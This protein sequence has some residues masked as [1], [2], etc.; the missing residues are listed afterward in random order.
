MEQFFDFLEESARR[1]IRRETPTLFVVDS[2]AGLCPRD[3]S[4]EKTRM[5]DSAPMARRSLILTEFFGRGFMTMLQGKN[6]FVVFINQARKAIGSPIPG[7]LETPGGLAFE[8]YGAL[9]LRI[10]LGEWIR[11][12]GSSGPK[13]GGMMT[14][15]LL[16]S[17]VSPTFRRATVP[18]Y[19]DPRAPVQGFDEFASW[20]S[21]LAGQGVITATGNGRYTLDGVTDTAA[22]WRERLVEDAVLRQEVRHLVIQA[23][24]KE[25]GIEGSTSPLDATSQV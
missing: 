25:H 12:D 24:L 22:G 9:R 17:C 13:V 6:V 23:F 5:V 18:W 3:R 21:Y 14:L 10:S 16:K 15:R 7:E 1:A 20:I 11:R 19:F 4:M 2:L 8:H